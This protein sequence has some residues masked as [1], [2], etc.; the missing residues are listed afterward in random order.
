MAQKQIGRLPVPPLETTFACPLLYA[1]TNSYGLGPFE[2]L[3]QV[4]IH[5]ENSVCLS[6]EETNRGT[7]HRWA[8]TP[9]TPG[10]Q[11]DR[12]GVD[13]QGWLNCGQL[14]QST[15]SLLKICPDIFHSHKYC[16]TK[17][18]GQPKYLHYEGK[19]K[20]TAAWL[21]DTVGDN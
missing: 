11:Q 1:P 4:P 10:N 20:R 15:Y 5:L 6:L 14:R 7:T 13:A 19:L 17:A 9:Y 2:V 18:K 8:A 21:K 12:R 3:M 16:S